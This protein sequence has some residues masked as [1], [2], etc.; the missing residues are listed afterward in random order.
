MCDYDRLTPLSLP[1]GS[2]RCQAEFAVLPFYLDRRTNLDRTGEWGH[3]M[4]P[5]VA[6]LLKKK[7]KKVD[8]MTFVGFFFFLFSPS[9][10]YILFCCASHSVF[11]PTVEWEH[12]FHHHSSPT[13]S[14]HYPRKALKG[15]RG[16]DDRFLPWLLWATAFALPQF[17]L[18]GWA[19]IAGVRGWVVAGGG[20]TIMLADILRS[21]DCLEGFVGGGL[22]GRW[23]WWYGMGAVSHK[24]L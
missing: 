21:C 24:D 2:F 17:P 5:P 6:L 19:L 15:Q 7:K 20:F 3:I 23:R 1:K 11:T 12:Y 16:E 22:G 14:P 4:G 13:R 9:L 8:W 10:C 18:H